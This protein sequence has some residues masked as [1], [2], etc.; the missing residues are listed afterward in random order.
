[1]DPS[2]TSLALSLLGAANAVNAH[3]PLATSGPAS[4]AAFAAGVLPS[5]L[6]LQHAAAQAGITTVLAA[7]G[8]LRGRSGAAGAVLSAATCAAYLHLHVQ[9]RRSGTLVDA[10]LVDALGPRYRTRMAAA[11]A[12]RWPRA[13]RAGTFPSARGRHRY[14]A[15]ADVA[16]GPYGRR[17]HLDV[18][19]RPDVPLDGRAP[20]LLQIHGGAW[21]TGSKETQALPLLS[22]MAERGWVCVAINY[23]LSPRSTWPDHIVD[24]K[25]ALAWVRAHIAEHGG[26]PGFVAV[27]GGSAGGHLA[28]LAALTPNDPGYQPGFEDADTTVQAAVPFYGVYDWTN[29][30]GSGRVDLQPLLEAKVFK[31]RYEDDPTPWDRASPMSHVGRHAPPFFLLHGTTDSLVPVAQARS[32]A[33]MLQEASGAPVAYAELPYAQHAFEIVDSVRSG[34]AVAA[35]DRFLA[36]AYGDHLRSEHDG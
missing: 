30:D 3:R 34:H 31:A 15:A 25:R 32:F 4:I 29:R 21:V 10:A 36:V 11:P 24:V 17:N 26:D 14:L 28:A 19:R 9:A 18:W 22:R 7:S 16:Y 6:P 5:E 27:T 8:G 1:M 13:R 33:H 2:R 12:G 20:V 35:V 23:R